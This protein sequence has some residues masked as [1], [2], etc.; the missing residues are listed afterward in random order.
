MSWLVIKS[1]CLEQV[2]KFCTFNKADNFKVLIW[3]NSHEIFFISHANISRLWTS[4]CQNCR[5]WGSYWEPITMAMHGSKEWWKFLWMWCDNY[6]LWSC[7][8]H[9][10]SSLFPGLKCVSFALNFGLFKLFF[11]VYFGNYKKVTYQIREDWIGNILS[12]E[13][14]SSFAP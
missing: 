8:H 5:G 6:K 2:L 10:G 11:A 14:Q 4:N 13:K 7:H 3:H 12:D 1:S 9:F